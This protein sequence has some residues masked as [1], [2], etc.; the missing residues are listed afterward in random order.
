[1][2]VLGSGFWTDE[3]IE[4]TLSVLFLDRVGFSFW[5]EGF[6]FALQFL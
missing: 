4:T 1:M 5:T 3:A 2:R 6:S